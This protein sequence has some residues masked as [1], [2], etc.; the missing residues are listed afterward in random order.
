MIKIFYC[1]L[2]VF[3]S[4]HRVYAQNEKILLS[5]D[6]SS[7]N[8]NWLTYTGN[9]VSYLLYNGKYIIES[10]D[11][12]VYR[13]GVPVSLDASKSYSIS[14]AAVHT[15]GTDNY[16]YG[17]YFGAKDPNNCFIFSISANG[18]YRADEDVNGTYTELVKWTETTAIKKGNYAENILKI[19]KEGRE[20]KFFVNDELLTSIPAQEF[21]GTLVGFSKGNAQRIEF[22]NLKVMQ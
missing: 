2:L 7:N 15:S 10:N 13:V 19:K 8:N 17:L 3:F 4:L 11:S 1:T 14:A 6:F 16:G 5:D 20:W 22:D 12:V 9:K 18:Y 21:K